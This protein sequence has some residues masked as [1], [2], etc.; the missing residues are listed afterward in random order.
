[1]RTGCGCCLPCAIPSAATRSNKAEHRA[2]HRADH[3]ADH[4][5]DNRAELQLHQLREVVLTSALLMRR[6]DGCVVHERVPG[7]GC[8]THPPM[9]GAPT[10]VSSVEF[11]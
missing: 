8:S 4:K 5:A 10:W 9:H 6:M 3:K 2:E 7:A 1:M 11:C